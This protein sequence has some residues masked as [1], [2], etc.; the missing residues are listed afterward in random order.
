MFSLKQ[1]IN[2]YSPVSNNS[3]QKLEEITEILTLAKGEIFVKK[4]H[5]DF[6]EYIV[7]DGICKSYV[8]DQDGEEVTLMFFSP[9]N[10]VSPHTIRIFDGASSIY[11]KSLTA[12]TLGRIDYRK[13]EELI[14]GNLEIRDFAN[15]VLRK[16]LLQKTVKELGLASLSAKE[17][18]VQFRSDFP[19][20]ENLIPHPDIASYLGIT[21]ISLSRLRN[22]RI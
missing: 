16:E 11:L 1:I 12:T 10:V 9:G 17:R 7:M 20:F 22:S 21:N 4:G 13:M 3:C 19:N 14:I 8:H 18:L 15:S 5:R 6:Y 2:S